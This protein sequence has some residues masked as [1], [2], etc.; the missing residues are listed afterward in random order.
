MYPARIRRWS[1]A[2]DIPPRS[3]D[4]YA[5]FADQSLSIDLEPRIFTTEEFLKKIEQGDRFAIESI[6]I[7][8]PLFGEDFIHDLK[9][10]CRVS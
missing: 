4:R 8:I 9:L 10:K 1:I 6:K 7:G 5:L 2:G 3:L